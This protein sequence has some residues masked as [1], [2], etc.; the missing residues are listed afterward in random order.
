MAA[1]TGMAIGEFSRRTGGNIETGQPQYPQTGITLRSVSRGRGPQT[2]RAIRVALHTQ[3]RQLAE[4]GRVR[5]QRVVGP[6]SRSPYPG[7]AEPDRGSRRLG[8]CP[9]QEITLKPIGSSPLP[10]PA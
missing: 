3:T 9:Q 5:T 8:A 10:M 6:M 1:Q 4:H 2:R 7:Q